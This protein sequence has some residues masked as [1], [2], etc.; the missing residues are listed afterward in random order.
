MAGCTRATDLG[1]HHERVANDLA[2]LL[3]RDGL[4]ERLGLNPLNV[5]GRRGKGVGGIEGFDRHAERLERLDHRRRLLV[6]H[7]AVVDV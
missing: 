3:R 5:R 1:D 4:P 6:A 2:L 7:E